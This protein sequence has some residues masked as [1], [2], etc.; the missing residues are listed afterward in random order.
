[1]AVESSTKLIIGV[2]VGGTNTDAV[3][4]NPAKSGAEAVIASYK[5]TTGADVTTGIE[6]AI[7][8]LLK[9]ARVQ[10]SQVASLM[11]GTTHLINAV[12]E[13]DASRLSKVAVLRL[14][15]HGYLQYTPPF[16]DF[17]TDLKNSRFQPKHI[18]FLTARTANTAQS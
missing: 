9:D 10:P 5:A 13:R 12:V 2:D 11:I 6:E 8:V 14:T 16:I 4:L 7:H 18:D 1:M 17:P 3:L 15:S